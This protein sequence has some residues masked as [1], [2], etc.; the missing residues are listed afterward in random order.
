[1]FITKQGLHVSANRQR[2]VQPALLRSWYSMRF[3][4]E[5]FKSL[6]EL[7]NSI[8]EAERQRAAT[9]AKENTVKAIDIHAPAP[10]SPS[11]LSLGGADA[12]H[13]DGIIDE[14]DEI[15]RANDRAEPIE[16]F[17]IN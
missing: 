3:F 2:V 9:A 10:A 6:R 1:M 14:F 15:V 17:H 16:H 7:R 12:E 5:A 11:S 8:Q 13:E 4:K